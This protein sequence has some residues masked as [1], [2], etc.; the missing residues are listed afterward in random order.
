MWEQ[1]GNVESECV[2]FQ[3]QDV[4]APPSSSVAGPDGTEAPGATYRSSSGRI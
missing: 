1:G 3:V 4:C 2:A